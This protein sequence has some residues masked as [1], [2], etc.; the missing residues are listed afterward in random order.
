MSMAQVV[1]PHGREPRAAHESLEPSADVLRVEGLAVGAVLGSPTT[2]R[3][4]TGRMVWRIAAR[5]RSRS[6]SLQRNP[7]AS[8]RRTP[9]SAMKSHRV[10]NRSSMV[11][12]RKACRSDADQTFISGLEALGG[13]ANAAGLRAINCQRTASASALCSVAWMRLMVDADRADVGGS[14]RNSVPYSGRPQRRRPSPPLLRLVPHHRRGPR[15]HLGPG[16]PAGHPR[17]RPL[18]GLRGP[19]PERAAHPHLGT[20]P[21]PPTTTTEGASSAPRE[22]RPSRSPPLWVEPGQRPSLP[23]TTRTT[24]TASSVAGSP[25]IRRSSTDTLRTWP[26]ARR[27]DAEGRQAAAE[28]SVTASETEAAEHA[29]RLEQLRTARAAGERFAQA[30]AWRA[31]DLA[32]LQRRREDVWAAAVVAAARHGDPRLRPATAQRRP[33][34][35]HDPGGRSRPGTDSGPRHRR[36]PASSSQDRPDRPRR[37]HC[38]FRPSQGGIS[39]RTGPSPCPGPPQRSEPTPR[40]R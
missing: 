23:G 8:P 7:S 37:R 28:R 20:P 21:P 18:P 10:A 15:R 12:A 4:P 32:A 13:S 39:R 5:P 26:P 30:N 16:P 9:V 2:A 35:P 6:T 3:C 36:L 14:G 17:P 40:S 31:D 25:T 22:R 11:A 33:G 29:A 27:H 34:A 24:P 1:Q 19:V 38:S